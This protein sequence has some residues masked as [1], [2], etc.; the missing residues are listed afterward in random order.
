MTQWE[1]W[2]SEEERGRKKGAMSS[3]KNILHAYV[4]LPKNEV[5]HKMLLICLNFLLNKYP[6]IYWSI[7]WW[8]FK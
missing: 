3:V 4:K 7:I 8:S 6:P 5:I 1:D 2:V